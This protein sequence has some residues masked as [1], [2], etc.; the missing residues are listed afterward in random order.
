MA[1][2]SIRWKEWGEERHRNIRNAFKVNSL[3]NY[4][5]QSVR[6]I[7]DGSDPPRRWQARAHQP[8]PHCRSERQKRGVAPVLLRFPRAVPPGRE[9]IRNPNGDSRLEQSLRARRR[10]LMVHMPRVVSCALPDRHGTSLFSGQVRAPGRRLERQIPKPAG[11]TTTADQR[12]RPDAGC[13]LPP[14]R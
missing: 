10:A 1:S 2:D 4:W 7:L 9:T 11:R 8:A 13:R 6:D 5:N 14:T 12:S 3:R